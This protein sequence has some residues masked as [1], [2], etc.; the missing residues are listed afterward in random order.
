VTATIAVMQKNDIYAGFSG[1]SFTRLSGGG[2]SFSVSVTC[3][4]A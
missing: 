1:G 3:S 4:T 2:V